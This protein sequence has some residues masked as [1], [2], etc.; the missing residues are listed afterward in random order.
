MCVL[1][2]AVASPFA[3]ARVHWTLAFLRLTLS[4]RAGST[5]CLRPLRG[6][7]RRAAALH[8]SPCTD[9]VE[10]TSNWTY[11]SGNP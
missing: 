3:G 11:S 10:H 9:T 8:E 6:F 2:R 5:S 1:R 4:L 7:A